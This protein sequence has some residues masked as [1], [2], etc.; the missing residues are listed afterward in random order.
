MD[1]L[2]PGA[3]AGQRVASLCGLSNHPVTSAVAERLIGEGAGRARAASAWWALARGLP[4]FILPGPVAGRAAGWSELFVTPGFSLE[5]VRI[6][7]AGAGVD[8]CWRSLIGGG[9]AF[10]AHGVPWLEAVVDERIKPVLN[11]FPVDRL[12]DP[13]GDLVQPRR[14]RRHLRRGRDPHS[15]L[16]D[17]YR[18]GPAQHRPRS[19][20]DGQELHPQPRAHVLAADLAAAGALWAFGNPH[21]LWR[22]PGRSRWSRNCSARPSGLGYLMLRAQTAADST[23][24][25]ATC[26]ADRADLRRRR[27]A[28]DRAAGAAVRAHGEGRLFMTT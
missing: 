5:P 3:A 15:V 20:G 2:R 22:S 4:E 23:T 13:R 10:L 18:R 9:L 14:L 25:L 6:D 28:G 1:Q 27:A 26:F 17:Q 8:R 24:F 11:S 21:R 12:G 19:H 16:P 7:M